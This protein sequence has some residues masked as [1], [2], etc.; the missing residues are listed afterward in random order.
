MVSMQ[1]QFDT[2]RFA[3]SIRTKRGNRSLRATAEEIGDISVAS[4]FRA[5]QAKRLPDLL[6]VLRICDWLGQ[7]I[8]EF[9]QTDSAECQ[10]QE[11]ALEQAELAL[12]MDSGLT[13]DL[14]EAVI[15]LLRAIRNKRGEVLQ[16]DSK[17][18]H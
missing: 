8:H 16:C 12:R 1:S 7:P 18:M 2:H 13:P 17:D 9:I 10:K 15:H 5:E 11:D 6:L 4:L 3:V 14:V